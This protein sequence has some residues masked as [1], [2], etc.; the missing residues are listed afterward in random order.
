MKRVLYIF[1]LI[2]LTVLVSCELEPLV[3]ISPNPVAPQITFPA[4]GQ[5]F[6]YTWNNETDSISI[7]WQGSD[8]G[9]KI[10]P[11]Y[12][13]YIDKTGNN[14]AKPV[15]LGTS[16]TDSLEISVSKLNTAI[17]RLKFKDGVPEDI[18]IKVVSF[19]N[20][21]VEDLTSAIIT[22]KFSTYSEPL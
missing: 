2:L 20:A 14:F 5:E 21:K 22:F 19:V 4:S 8:Y 9:F 16:T 18:D 12:S 7:V 10:A 15:K 1:S 11:S 17:K 13:V 3:Q 6:T